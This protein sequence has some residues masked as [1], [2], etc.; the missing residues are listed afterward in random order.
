MAGFLAD[1]NH[2]GMPTYVFSGFLKNH[3]WHEL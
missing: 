1:L 2:D 3:V